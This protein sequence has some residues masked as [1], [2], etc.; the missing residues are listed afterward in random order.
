MGTP[1]VSKLHPGMFL[2]DVTQP[3][4]WLE[5][6]ERGG[7]EGVGAE[8]HARSFRL[9]FTGKQDERSSLQAPIH[10]PRS[11]PSRASPR[12]VPA[13]FLQAEKKKEKKTHPESD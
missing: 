8:E 1:E 11:S 5:K 6:R 10:A 3:Q 4:V 9:M 12:R 13:P 2:P 7:G